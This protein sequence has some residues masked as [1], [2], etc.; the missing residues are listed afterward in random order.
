MFNRIAATMA[1]CLVLSACSRPYVIKGTGDVLVDGQ[2]VY[3]LDG[4]EWSV[5]DSALVENGS[6]RIKGH[7]FGSQ[8][9]WLYMGETSDTAQD[10]ISDD[11]FFLEPGTATAVYDPETGMFSVSGTPW[12]DMYSDLASYFG[13][14]SDELAGLVRENHNAFGLSVLSEMCGMY[15][16]ADV[17]QLMDDFPDR[18]KT[19]PLY[20]SLEEFIEPIKGDLGLQYYDFEGHNTDGDTVTLGSIVNREGVRYVLLDFWAT[21]CGPC[22]AEI[23]ALVKLYENFRNAGLEIFGVSFD[24]NSDKWAEIVREYDMRWP[25]VITEF[26]SGPRSSTIWQAYGLDGI[27]WNYLIDTSTGEIIAKNIHGETLYS[28]VEKLLK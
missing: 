11:M 22:R 23:P 14:G 10:Q 21:W 17:R 27:P 16:T 20:V 19:H 13:N 18:M 15:S 28:K 4:V 26:P 2:W 8:T 24:H 6:F 12:N 9:G 3:V 1:F 25:N 5:L 7:N